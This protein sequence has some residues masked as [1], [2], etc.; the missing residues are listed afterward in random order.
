MQ[1]IFGGC[2]GERNSSQNES[3]EITPLTHKSELIRRR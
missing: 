1:F 3:L 2:L